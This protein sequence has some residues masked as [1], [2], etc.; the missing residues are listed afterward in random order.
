MFNKKY[1]LIEVESPNGSDVHRE[2]LGKVCYLAYFNIGERG[3][4]LCDTEES[5]NP[6]HRI[7]TSNVRYVQ[8]LRGNRVVVLTEN[9]KYVFEVILDGKED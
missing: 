9:T 4:F 1:R 6:V 5:F 7:H 2:C 3:W 8:H